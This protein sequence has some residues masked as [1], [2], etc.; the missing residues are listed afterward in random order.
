MAAW[1]PQLAV[2]HDDRP[3]Q[4]G[5]Q[6]AS[7]KRPMSSSGH[8]QLAPDIRTLIAQNEAVGG[9]TLPTSAG[10]GGQVP[11]GPGTG[12]AAMLSPPAGLEHLR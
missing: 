7:P 1:Q 8:A 12:H 10:V 3:T 6:P 2:V 11:R 4:P 9:G 5:G